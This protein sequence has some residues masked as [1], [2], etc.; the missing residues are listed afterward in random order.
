[1]KALD[2][3]QIGILY[4]YLVRNCSD[5]RLARELLDH[6]ACEVEHYMWIGLPF[7]KAFEKVQLDV[8]TQAIR[9]LQQTYHHE[10]ADADQLQ[11]ATL[12]DIV[13]ENRNKAYG[14][15]DL[16]QSYTIAMRNALILTIGLFLMLMALLVAMKERTWS[17]TSLSGIM[18]LVGLCATTFAGGNWYWQN[19]RQKLL[20]PE[21][22]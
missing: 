14:A 10:L 20:T 6:L 5:T 18:W 22:Y 7:D 3:Q 16:R 21:Q 11:T 4:D 8:D 15:Y 17:Y 19:I 1:M 12:D 2:R 13:F 9:Q